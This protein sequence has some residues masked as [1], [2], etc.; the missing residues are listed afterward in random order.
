MKRLKALGL[1]LGLLVLVVGTPTRA[2]EQEAIQQAVDRGVMALRAMGGDIGHPDG[3]PALAGL[4]LLECGVRPDDPVMAGIINRV[5][6][7]STTTAQT[8]NLALS[9][10]FLDRL[11]DPADIPLLES[12]TVRLLAGQ[13]TTGGWTYQCP[14]PGPAETRRL[15]NL[16]GQR[17]EL[18]GRTRLP[19]IEP[20]NQGEQPRVRA[21]EKLGR[22]TVRDLAP[23][24]QAQL[25]MLARGGV[26]RADGGDNSNT[27]FGTLGLW[28][29]RKYGVPVDVALG[30][31]RMRF[32]TSQNQ[33]GGWGYNSG[34][35]H[36]DASTATM[37]CAGLIGL[38]VSHGVAAVQVM[39]RD[40]KAV[41]ARNAGRD[42]NLAGGLVAL[43]GLINHPI[44]KK[45]R[46]RGPRPRHGAINGRSY[47]FLWSVER[48]AVALDLDTIGGKDWYAWG[49]EIL[50]DNQRPDGSWQGDHGGADTCFALLFLR[51]ANLAKDLTA[52]LRG[53]IQDPNEVVLRSGGVGGGGLRGPSTI[54]PGL[55][56]G[57]S[58]KPASEPAATVKNPPREASQPRRPPDTRPANPP[59]GSE[60][61]RLARELILADRAQQERSLTQA[62]RQQGGRLHRGPGPRHPPAGR[63]HPRQG[64]ASPGRA[65][66]PPEGTESGK[67]SDR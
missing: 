46:G 13:T 7:G 65:A 26:P 9:I 10:L 55:E 8:Y 28:V 34:G 45:F 51:R 49:S 60:S 33:D 4:A 22:R 59:Q 24:I 31:V 38:A 5:R 47:Y 36:K 2:A 19:G 42:V 20:G 44:A 35:Q 57:T 29:G 48:L 50:I 32:C 56:T 41:P 23:E 25:T 3:G 53:K 67:V 17:A 39:E 30:G 37:T 43:G 66:D 14:P 63:G 54:K 15:S 16:L 58:K 1:S 52:A 61:A 21:P 6:Q 64:P 12:L 62:A 18:V 11:G 27:Q 40:P